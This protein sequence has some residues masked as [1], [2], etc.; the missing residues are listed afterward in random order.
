MSIVLGPTFAAELQA[1]GL[2]SVVTA[3]DSDGTIHNRASLTP[4]Q[5]TTLEAVIAAH[6]PAKAGVPQSISS[7]QAKVALLRA[8]LLGSVEAWVNTQGAETQLVWNTT[9][10]FNRNSGLIATGGAALGMTSAQLDA[11]FITA[12]GINL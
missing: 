10:A 1:A 8:G 4:A 7:V 9:P 3:W 5:E 6:N 12:A 2:G 11:L